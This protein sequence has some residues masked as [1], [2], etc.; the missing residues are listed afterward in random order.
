MPKLTSPR[1]RSTTT[2]DRTENRFSTSK[3]EPGKLIPR[4]DFLVRAHGQY[5]GRQIRNSLARYRHR[6]RDVANLMEG[7]RKLIGMVE[8]IIQT[9]NVPGDID[10]TL[11]ILQDMKELAD[12]KNPE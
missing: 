9:G 12:S 2:S 5:R 11:R 3:S 6:L 1:R 4:L 10:Q 7:E 8:E